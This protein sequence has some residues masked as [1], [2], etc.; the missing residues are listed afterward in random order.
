VD[1]IALEPVDDIVITTLMDNSYDA[2]MGDT[3][4]ARRTPFARTELG[5]NRSLLSGL[6]CSDGPAGE[7]ENLS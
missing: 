6:N 1:P 3:A 4:S 2:L 5:R 7:G